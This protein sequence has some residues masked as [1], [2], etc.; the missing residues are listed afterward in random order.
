LARSLDRRPAKNRIAD[1]APPLFF[2]LRAYVKKLPMA[3]LKFTRLGHPVLRTVTDNI[4]VKE[5]KTAAL[6]RFIE[7]TTSIANADAP[8]LSPLSKNRVLV[9]DAKLRQEGV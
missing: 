3:I 4:S 1:P 9:L 2:P 5:L 8:R 6:Q 7:A